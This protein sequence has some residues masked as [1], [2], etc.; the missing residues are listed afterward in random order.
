MKMQALLRRHALPGGNCVKIVDLPQCFDDV[1]TFIRKVVGHLEKIPSAVC[2]AICQQG[3]KLFGGFARQ[4]VAHL[5]RWIKTVLSLVQNG[6][7]V[8][9]GMFATGAEY[10]D[11]AAVEDREDAGC[12]DSRPRKF[13]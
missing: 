1:L 3:L 9:G 12:E 6:R 10:G 11:L 8:F 4:G 7:Q 13:G 2:E 5:D